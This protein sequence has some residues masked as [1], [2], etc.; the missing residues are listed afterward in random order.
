MKTTLAAVLLF[1]GMLVLS[2]YGPIHPKAAAQQTTSA[3][4]QTPNNFQVLYVR[5][6]TELQNKLNAEAKDGWAPV[7]I[8]FGHNSLIAVLGRHK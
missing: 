4:P 7:A 2:Y 8:T 6:E 5:D 1:L 3:A